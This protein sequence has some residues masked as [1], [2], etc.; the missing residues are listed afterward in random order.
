MD[1]EAVNVILGVVAIVLTLG[2]GWYGYVRIFRRPRP[3]F[4]SRTFDLVQLAAEDRK[5]EAERVLEGEDLPTAMCR[6]GWWNAGRGAAS[7]VVIDVETPGEI[8]D[9]SLSPDQEDVRGPWEVT[10]DPFEGGAENH[11][12]VRQ[13]SL[14]P[15]SRFDLAVGFWPEREGSAQVRC[16]ADGREIPKHGSS[17]RLFFLGLL[18]GIVG[19]FVASVFVADMVR[20]L[21]PGWDSTSVL[22]SVAVVILGA[23]VLGILFAWG[24]PRMSRFLLRVDYVS[25]AD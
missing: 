23:A 17:P 21:R 24:L 4:L 25:G 18:P 14:K 8:V 12:R 6:L 10:Q 2:S 1:V 3:Y 22:I 9:Y 15:G 7:D 11:I 16:Y 5:A 19:G 13:E 20:D